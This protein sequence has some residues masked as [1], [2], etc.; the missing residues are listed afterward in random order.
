VE[1]ISKN[2]TNIRKLTDEDLV[3]ISNR[4]NDKLIKDDRNLF[5]RTRDMLSDTSDDENRNLNNNNNKSPIKQVKPVAKPSGKEDDL[6]LEKG[7][8]YNKAS[9]EMESIGKFSKSVKSHKITKKVFNNKGKAKA[10]ITANLG[11]INNTAI[12]KGRDT[13]NEDWDNEL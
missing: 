5:P 4:S 13:I 3:D 12:G 2:S 10:T 6:L 11:T 8:D 1:N 9:S 7:I